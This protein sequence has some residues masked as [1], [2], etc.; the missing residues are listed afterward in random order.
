MTRSFPWL[1]ACVVLSIG[2]CGSRSNAPTGMPRKLSQ[3]VVSIYTLGDAR[4]GP[5][6]TDGKG[7]RTGWDVNHAIDGITGCAYEF[8][9]EDGIPDENAPE[10]T[11]PL[12]PADTV[13]GHP[14][15]TPIFH[16]FSITD[17]LGQPGLL[18]EG[19]CELRLAPDASGRAVLALTGLRNGAVECQDTTSVD[20][21][22]GVPS[23]WWLSWKATGSKCLVKITR[24]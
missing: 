1:L 18:S 17:S 2:A 5:M 15:P 10:D 13:P 4:V 3:V 12:A 21:K 6:L 8:G 22:L 19:R 20:V 16:Y 9:S 7:R 11:A 23:R 24:R 14:E